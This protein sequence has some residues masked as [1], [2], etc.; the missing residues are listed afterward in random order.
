MIDVRITVGEI[1]YEKTITTLYP[2]VMDKCRELRDPNL[3]VRLFL[4]LGED[5]LTVLLGIME[6]LSESAKHEFLCQCMNVYRTILT[7]KLNEFL[8]GNTWGRNFVIQSLYVERTED[9]LELVGKGV[10]VDYKA[11]L[12]REDVQSKINET[13]VSH[14]G[15]LGGFFAEH[16]GNALKK[17]A[18]AAPEKTEEL[19]LMLLQRESVKGRLLSLAQ[20]ALDK[21]ELALELQ[22]VT[23][24]AAEAADTS[25]DAQADVHTLK[26]SPE[27][28][29]ELIK[30]LGGYL[31]QTVRQEEHSV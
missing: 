15:K 23:I 3:L 20:T 2:A 8:Q 14:L 22:T 1:G 9:R 31:R 24:L 12:E 28:E 13:A 4:E 17:A 5:V 19:G 16:A 21:R 10:N 30:A 27:L 25:R 6:R 11:L 29:T 7:D 26:I 18:E